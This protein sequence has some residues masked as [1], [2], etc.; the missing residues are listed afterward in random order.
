LAEKIG[1]MTPAQ[2]REMIDAIPAVQKMRDL[3]LMMA[4]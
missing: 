3:G 2:C 4:D 1:A